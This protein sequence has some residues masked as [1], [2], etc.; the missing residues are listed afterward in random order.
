MMKVIDI[1]LNSQAKVEKANNRIRKLT[2]EHE[3]FK[4]R[5]D[6][7]AS[8]YKKI[9]KDKHLENQIINDLT[10]KLESLEAIEREQQ[11]K[12]KTV[13]EYSKEAQTESIEKV[14]ELYENA[15]DHERS[16]NNRKGQNL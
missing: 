4:D 5:Y 12:L 8:E 16:K 2:I 7:L 14:L 3:M 15:T 10:T 11:K 1:K 6:N 9:I 13:S